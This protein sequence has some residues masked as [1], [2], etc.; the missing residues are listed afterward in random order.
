MCMNA[1]IVAKLSVRLWYFD[2][3]VDSGFNLALQC[4]LQ[5]GMCSKINVPAI[6]LGKSKGLGSVIWSN[7]WFYNNPA[8]G[9]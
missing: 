2:R 7:G 6:N 5:E 3:K 8:F 4:L 1:N 9:W